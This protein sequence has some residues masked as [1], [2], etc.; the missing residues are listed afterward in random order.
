LLAAAPSTLDR[1]QPRGV[2]SPP[3]GFSFSVIIFERNAKS[4]LR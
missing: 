2:A 1:Q 4:V 3:R